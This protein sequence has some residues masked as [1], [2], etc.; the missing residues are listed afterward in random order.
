MGG[1]TPPMF[2]QSEL[3]LSA[4]ESV[5]GQHNVIVVHR[6]GGVIFF[7]DDL[8]VE[9]DDKRWENVIFFLQQRRNR[10]PGSVVMGRII[11]RYHF[12]TGTF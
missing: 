6:R 9:F 2:A 11:Y 5:D 8:A 7:F 3:V 4:R 12:V 1:I 10:H